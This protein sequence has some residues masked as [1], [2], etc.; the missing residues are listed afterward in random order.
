MG[1]TRIGQHRVH[2]DFQLQHQVA[3]AVQCGQVFRS[4]MAVGAGRD[5]DGVFAMLVH[6]DESGAGGRVRHQHAVQVHAGFTQG[7]FDRQGLGVMAQGQQHVGGVAAGL[8]AGHG[9]VG[10]LATGPGPE[11]M[12]QHRFTGGGDVRCAHHVIEIGGAGDKNHGRIVGL[13]FLVV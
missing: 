12:A 9:L 10:P 2:G 13:N 6:A 7:V 1:G 8:A 4:Q 3:V 11:V 5:R